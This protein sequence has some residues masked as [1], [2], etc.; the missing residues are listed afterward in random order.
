MP[1][2]DLSKIYKN[3]YSAKR[4]PE[5]LIVEAVHFISIE[6][7]GDPSGEVFAEKIDALY[8]VAY[9]IKFMCKAAGND[10]TV[11]KLEGLWY[12]DPGKYSGVSISEAP[13]KIPRDQW[14]YRLLIRLPD[15]VRP[16]QVQT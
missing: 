5:L 2:I 16:G 9:A 3:Y 12:F 7:K 4:K 14:E 1:K 8:P 11:P 6:G 13:Q 10:F 15:F